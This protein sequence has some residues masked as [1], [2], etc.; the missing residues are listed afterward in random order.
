MI[1]DLK[2]AREKKSYDEGN[3]WENSM[4]LRRIFRHVFESK[5]TINCEEWFNSKATFL[6]KNSVVLDYG[7]LQGGQAP[8]Y[9]NHGANKLIG[10]DIS[11]K[12]IADAKIKFGNIAEFHVCDA[13]EIRFM[14]DSCIDLVIGR[15]ILHHL[16][17]EKAI[18]E[19]LRVLKPGGSALF[20]EPLY[21]NPLSVIFRLLTPSARTKDERPL[22]KKQIE[23]ANKMFSSNEIRF[24]NL[25]STPIAMITSQLP[26]KPSNPLLNFADIIDRNLEKTWLKYWMRAAY[27]HWIK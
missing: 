1:M 22:S 7:C 17:F 23:W 13:H 6:C 21:D 9:I 15:G 19:V 16:D 11:E 3:V 2:V 4:R 20:A 25:I 8:F 14:E 12:G 26:I 24:C 5:N 18:K 27:F 10:I